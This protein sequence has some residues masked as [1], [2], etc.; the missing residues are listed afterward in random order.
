MNIDE[1]KNIQEEVI[2]KSK[3]INIVM[4]II[5][6]LTLFII[7]KMQL[8]VH[9]YI[10]ATIIMI[11]LWAI[12]RCIFLNKKISEFNKGFKNIFVLE[13]LTKIFNNLN[14]EP[15]KGLDYNVI[16]DTKMM[17]MGDRY[18]SNDYFE[19][20]YKDVKVRHA[21]VNI[22]EK[23]ETTDSEGNT[24][25]TWITIFE[26][27]WMI[28]DFNKTFNA[29]IQVS[30]KG[31]G[32]SVISNWGEKNKYKKIEMEDSNFNK[33]FRVYAQNEHDAFYILTPSL[34]EKIK[35]LTDQIDG[36]MLFCF[37]NN[38]LHVGLLNYKDSFEYN[39]Y[40][41]ID[42]EKIKSDIS[43]DIKIITSFVDELNLDNNLFRKGV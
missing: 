38:E 2:R 22:Q 31:F 14:Y 6:A 30:Q 23:H 10:F 32:N 36:K 7:F 19:A 27:K 42:E 4:L 39:I 8:V 34:M 37:I 17:Y 28:F 21:D 16:A 40:K 15:D 9:Y 35:K 20:E 24:T 26:G 1:L 11:I 3:I 12:I 5:L 29:N 43:H 33:M 25:T 18:Y 13:A 41:R